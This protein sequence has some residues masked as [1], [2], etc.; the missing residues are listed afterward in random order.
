MG[1][2]YEGTGRKEKKTVKFFEIS[3]YGAWDRGRFVSWKSRYYSCVFKLEDSVTQGH[4][5]L[6]FLMHHM[7]CMQVGCISIHSNVLLTW[8]FHRK[9]GGSRVT[10][11]GVGLVLL[12]AVTHGSNPS[13]A[14]KYSSSAPKDQTWMSKGNMAFPMEP[15]LTFIS[16]E[17]AQL[18]PCSQ[19][20]TKVDQSRVTYMASNR[21]H[22]LRI[23][24]RLLALI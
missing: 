17:T 21:G 6:F 18:I 16:R 15:L 9:S 14:M 3:K 1:T 24:F 13:W 23:E 10:R 8:I 19:K 12:P 4:Y 22:L 7:W 2:T 11:V 5:L 20:K